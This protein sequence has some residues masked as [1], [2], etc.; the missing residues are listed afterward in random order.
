M[1]GLMIDDLLA[2]DRVPRGSWP[3]TPCESKGRWIIESVRK[4]YE[5]AGLPRHTG[6]AVEYAF[7]C[8]FWDCSC[9]GREG[10]T[11]PLC[12]WSA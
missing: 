2:M 3:Q 1:M 11:V 12:S 6:K 5:T 9:D 10:S 4:A 8:D 7:V